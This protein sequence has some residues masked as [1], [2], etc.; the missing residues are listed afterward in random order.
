MCMHIGENLTQD[1]WLY[2]VSPGLKPLSQVCFLGTSIVCWSCLEQKK[3][4][5]YSAPVSSQLP[6]PATPVCLEEAA[7]TS[8]IHCR[9]GLVPL[10]LLPILSSKPDV[11]SGRS[12]R[13]RRGLGGDLPALGF[14]PEPGSS[15]RPR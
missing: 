4:C 14:S 1:H 10:S 5:N 12:R 15:P 2:N 13:P 3:K 7:R 9:Q 6:L 11:G 8:T